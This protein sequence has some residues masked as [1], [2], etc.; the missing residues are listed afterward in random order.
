[1]SLKPE[2]CPGAE[3]A[4]EPGA[5]PEVAAA[6]IPEVRRPVA[7]L[8]G[9]A[10]LRGPAAPRAVVGPPEAGLAVSPEAARAATR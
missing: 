4:M 6:G 7:V 3:A 9:A 2:V 10:V 8:Q 5:A 1:M